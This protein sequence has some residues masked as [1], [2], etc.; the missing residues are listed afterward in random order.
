MAVAVNPSSAEM[1]D[2]GQGQEVTRDLHIGMVCTEQ[3]CWK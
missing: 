1:R 2:K 3:C